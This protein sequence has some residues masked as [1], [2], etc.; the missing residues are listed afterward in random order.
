M[1]TTLPTRGFCRIRLSEMQQ[2]SASHVSVAD[3]TIECAVPDAS[4]PAVA[5]LHAPMSQQL[6]AAPFA[7][8]LR[9]CCAF[10][11]LD[12][13]SPGFFRLLCVAVEI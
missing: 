11:A 1:A 7:V 10:F 8:E 13:F 6:S 2:V 12:T 3:T 9:V 5:R 4:S